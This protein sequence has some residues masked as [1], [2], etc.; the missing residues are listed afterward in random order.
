MVN[1]SAEPSRHR[2]APRHAFVVLK[3]LEAAL[4]GATTKGVDPAPTRAKKGHAVG[5]G[6]RLAVGQGVAAVGLRQAAHALRAAT[7]SLVGASDADAYAPTRR[8]SAS[9]RALK[10][11]DTAGL[12]DLVVVTAALAPFGPARLLLPQLEGPNRL[13]RSRLPG[14]L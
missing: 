13:A 4:S 11:P 6:A 2:D 14:H 9:I 3:P 10:V 8:P 12:R 7:K 5:S 1:A